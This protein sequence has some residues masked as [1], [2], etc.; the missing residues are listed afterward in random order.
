MGLKE[1]KNEG[2]KSFQ[3]NF[4]FDIGDE[5][6]LYYDRSIKEFKIV[7]SYNTPIVEPDLML[8]GLAEAPV[9]I[10]L[11]NMAP[12]Y[13]RLTLIAAVLGKIISDLESVR[14]TGEAERWR[15]NMLTLL[16]AAKALATN[17]DITEQKDIRICIDGDGAGPLDEFLGGE[18]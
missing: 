13:P 15:H 4:V 3:P 18:G 10:F 6:V 2:S 1:L 17:P 16:R 9:N 11:H 8:L 5:T 14:Y 7:S 12:H